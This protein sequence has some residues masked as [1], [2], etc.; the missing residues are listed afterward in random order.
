MYY[1]KGFFKQNICSFYPRRKT[2]IVLS[3][4]SWQETR[5]V[6]V[7]NEVAKVMFLHLS[8]ILF[9]GGSVSV[10]ALIPPP[11]KYTPPEA[12]TH[13]PREA[14]PPWEAPPREAH[15]PPLR[16][17]LPLRT[18][19]ILLECNSCWQIDLQAKFR[20]RH[21]YKDL[22]GTSKKW[23]SLVINIPSQLVEEI[24]FSI[25]IVCGLKS[26]FAVTDIYVTKIFS[27]GTAFQMI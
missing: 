2:Y 10:H 27:L 8:V 24:L 16:R 15:P 11:G 26:L 22:L 23:T 4:A 19:R 20:Y 14:H 1:I 5:L 13:T 21:H 9:T 3:N 7:R 12:H 17:R 6:T 25:S 18:V